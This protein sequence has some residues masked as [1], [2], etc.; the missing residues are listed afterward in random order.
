MLPQKE[1]AFPRQPFQT[2][3]SW[4]YCHELLTFNMLTESEMWLS[5]FLQFVW[6][7]M[8]WPWGE[9]SG[10][11]VALCWHIPGYCRPAKCQIFCFY[12]G[13]HT[14]SWS[15]IHVSCSSLILIYLYWLIVHTHTLCA[16][17][18]KLYFWA[19]ISLWIKDSQSKMLMNLNPNV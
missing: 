16:Q 13:G 7:R 5:S 9:L 10:K 12:W 14:C 15:S 2:S 8:I 19:L 11:I 1:E 18:L 17:L 6:E 3:R 4:L